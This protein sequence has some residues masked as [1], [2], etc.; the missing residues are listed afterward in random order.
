MLTARYFLRRCTT[1]LLIV[2]L[3]PL[4]VHAV[5]KERVTGVVYA[6]INGNGVRESG[7]RGIAGVLV[8]NQVDVVPTDEKGRYQLSLDEGTVI[9]LTK[10]AGYRVPL[11]AY[12]LPQFYYVHQTK[13][14]PEGL[15][16]PGVAPTG[17]LPQALDFPLLQTGVEETFSAIISGDPQLL[18]EEEVGYF[19]D[20]VAAE[21][22]LSRLPRRRATNVVEERS[23]ARASQ[24]SG[25][26]DHAHCHSHRIWRPGS[27]L[28]RIA[29]GSS[30]YW[31]L[32]STFWP[33]MDTTTSSNR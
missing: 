28:L 26:P 23:V 4:A 5:G 30:R 31:S 24:S 20:D 13:G 9:F 8:S 1:Y 6:D 19:R 7:E 12:N 14:S 29:R 3:V 11:N 15:K 27:R 25:R 17:P 18:N 16:Y 32:A 2:Q 21:R 33:S 10:P 22:S